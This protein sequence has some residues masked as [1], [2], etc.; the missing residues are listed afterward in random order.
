[1]NQDIINNYLSR[2]LST[3][4]KLAQDL[5]HY[6][7]Q[8]KYPLRQ[9]IHNNIKEHINN[10]LNP[11][12]KLINRWI[13][14]PGLRGVGKTTLLAQTYLWLN[15]LN[16]DINLIY[17]SLDQIT[18][19]KITLEDI[20]KAYEAIITDDYY[21]N[22]D[23]P[24]FILIDEVQ[25]DPNW[26]KTLK[27]IYD[28]SKR[29]F[30]LCSGS[31]ALHLQMDANTAGRR[32]LIEKIHPLS[33]TEFQLLSS[34]IAIPDISQ[35]IFEAIYYSQDAK[36]VYQKLKQYDRVVNRYW[37][38]IKP[39][40]LDKYLTIGTMPLALHD[41]ENQ[42]QKLILT[43][44]DKIIITDLKSLKRFNLTTLESIP[45]A[46]FHL[47]VI[48]N[49]LSLEKL[50]RSL[51]LN[52]KQLLSILNTLVMAEILIKIPAYGG[53]PFSSSRKSA[54]YNFMS[55]SIRASYFN[56]FS[57][58][59]MN[60]T[61]RGIL[62][63]DIASLHYYQN[64]ISSKKGYLFHN[65]GEAQADFILQIEREKQIAIEFS[66]SSKNINQVKRTMSKIKCQYGLIFAKDQLKL[67]SL[68]NIIHIPLR[69]F[70]LM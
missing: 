9:N 5:T 26:A 20:L 36:E 39:K 14:M 37:L 16:L 21:E 27:T 19:S 15:S 30:F 28:R 45:K 54:C 57:S 17:F 4:L 13:V 58:P 56:I 23:K 25:V 41:D 35:K 11:C 48:N 50:S 32:A 52:K 40:S 59:Q 34:N 49:E 66:L 8:T 18:A 64:F 55:S 29:V 70:L 67:N 44:I 38:N 12:D 10:F 3:N 43:I 42:V 22:L 46:L 7:D 2:Q 51:L 47:A 1:M 65:P 68:E 69:Y 31:S 61:R 53:S 33:F 24:T 63:E 60:Q 6:P 62:L